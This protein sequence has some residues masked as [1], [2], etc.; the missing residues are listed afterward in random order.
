MTQRADVQDL[1]IALERG[2]G[3]LRTE[4]RGGAPGPEAPGPLAAF[5]TLP[6]VSEILPD[7]CSKAGRL[8]SARSACAMPGRRSA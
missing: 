4:V 2:T 8:L 6:P 5:L 1:E 3:E 7:L